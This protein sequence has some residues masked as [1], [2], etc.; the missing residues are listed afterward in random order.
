[1]ETDQIHTALKSG[2][3][4]DKCIG[5]TLVVIETGKHRIFEAHA[6]LTGK[7]I[8]PDEPYHFI[9]REGIL[10]RHDALAF[11]PKRIVD[12]DRQM[13]AAL[14]EVTFKLRKDSYG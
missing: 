12:T 9:Q 13:A 8:L 5:M 10:Y 6:S 4:P 3:Q 2:E 7:V 11:I 14:L 1:M